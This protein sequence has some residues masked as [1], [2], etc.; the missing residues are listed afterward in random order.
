MIALCSEPIDVAAVCN[1]ARAK[2]FGSVVLFQGVVRLAGARGKM[3]RELYYESYGEV[4]LAEMERIADE[5]RARWMPC[6]VALV[7]R[8][9]TLRVG[10]SSVAIAVGTPHRAQA[11]EACAY[12]I[13]QLKARAAIWKQERYA[14]GSACWLDG[15]APGGVDS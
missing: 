13:E 11:F 1:A 15:G 7:H 6:A 12:A 3:V 4:A 2:S 14:D 9:G 8:I 5:V 10:E